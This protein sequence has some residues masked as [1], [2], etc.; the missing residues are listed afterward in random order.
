MM[1]FCYHNL[2]CSNSQNK[3]NE[4]LIPVLRC[5]CNSL[6]MITFEACTDSVLYT[7]FEE[8]LKN[9]KSSKPQ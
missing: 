8:H 6:K 4:N 2:L 3:F 7:R 1:K 5:V 9:A